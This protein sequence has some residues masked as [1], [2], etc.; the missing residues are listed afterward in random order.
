MDESL[1][2][3]F[4]DMDASEYDKDPNV[5]NRLTKVSGELVYVR[6]QSKPYDL[7]LLTGTYQNYLLSGGKQPW[8]QIGENQ[9]GRTLRF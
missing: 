7:V 1:K 9:G 6:E 2:L 5:I 4:W 8:F 3:L